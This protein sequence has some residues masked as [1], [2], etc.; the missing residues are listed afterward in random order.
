MQNLTVIGTQW[1]DEGKGKFVDHVA[2][3]FRVVCRFQGGHNAGH[4]INVDSRQLVFHLLPS[5]V[6]SEETVCA[7]GLGVVIS[8]ESLLDEYADL[9]TTQITLKP[10][11]TCQDYQMACNMEYNFRSRLFL[12][13]RCSII[14]P[15]HK[16]LDAA[17]EER[18]HRELAGSSNE[19]KKIGTT[20]KGIGP[21]YSDISA[22]TAIKVMDL[23][24]HS[25]LMQKLRVICAEHKLLL[26][27]YSDVNHEKVQHSINPEWVAYYL[28][29]YWSKVS[30]FVEVV[31]VSMFLQWCNQTQ[32]P[33]LF[34]GAQGALLDINVGSWPFVTS[35]STRASSAAI[36]TGVSHTMTGTRVG[37]AKSYQT[38]VGNGV[39]PT[40][41]E[42]E[43]EE[44]LRKVG[45]EY[46]ATTGRDRRCGWLDLVL[47][48]EVVE[49]DALDAICLTKADILENFESIKVA[50]EYV[51]KDN[52]SNG[53]MRS[54]SINMNFIANVNYQTF[55]S[56]SKS[57]YNVTEPSELDKDF[58]KFGCFIEDYLGIPIKWISTGPKRDQLIEFENG[59]RSYFKAL[60]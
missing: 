16:F 11:K 38:R 57:I 29:E 39:F 41:L 20:G 56:W 37:I 58:V 15:S 33:I 36:G 47:L 53:S 31:D 1:G 50:T 59:I 40:E 45:N 52:A 24:N 26:S 23:D 42:G 34:E 5:G 28:A 4:T 8:L 12:D 21:A 6:M 3:K 55:D 17:R 10:N 9:R 48:K 27:D 22:R 51:L 32:L 19:I 44:K 2:E 13:P 54:A 49:R 30:A 14:L 35:S 18:M 46:G 43:L 7:H 25:I 60:S